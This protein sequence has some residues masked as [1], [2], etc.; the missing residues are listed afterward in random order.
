MIRGVTGIR[1]LHT[2]E[3]VQRVLW[4]HALTT[5]ERMQRVPWRMRSL[6]FTTFQP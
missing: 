4:A 5:F 6:R 3:R 1:C 2:F